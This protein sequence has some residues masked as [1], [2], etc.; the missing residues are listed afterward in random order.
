[1]S[2]RLENRRPCRV[3]GVYALVTLVGLAWAALPHGPAI[4]HEPIALAVSVTVEVHDLDIARLSA[5]SFGD[6]DESIDP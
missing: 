4:P 1:M 5:A 6:L 3:S 2:S